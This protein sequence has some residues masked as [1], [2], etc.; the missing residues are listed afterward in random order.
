[1][2]KLSQ[3]DVIKVIKNSPVIIYWDDK[4]NPKL[5]F[6]TVE[7]QE[8]ISKQIEVLI[9][10]IGYF[11]ECSQNKAIDKA[12]LILQTSKSINDEVV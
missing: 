10:T 7:P 4:D 8:I 11:C 5:L 6:K 3:S 2:N 12:M 1:M 9:K